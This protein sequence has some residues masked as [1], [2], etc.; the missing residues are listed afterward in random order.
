MAI[1]STN[2]VIHRF[3]QEISAY[4]PGGEFYSQI[5]PLD[6]QAYAIYSNREENRFFYVIGDGEHT[7]TEIRDGKGNGEAYKEYPVLTK[8][9]LNVIVNGVE[10]EVKERKA[11]DE[12]LQAQIDDKENIRKQIDEYLQ[13]QIDENDESISEL[14]R[15]LTKEI[16]ER[17]HFDELLDEALSEEIQNREDAIA[18][19]FNQLKE[20]I[21]SHINDKQNP[22]KVTKAQVGLSNVDNTSDLSKPISIATQTALDLKIDK[23]TETN[24]VYGTDSL[25]NQTTYDIESFSKVDDVKINGTSVVTDKVASFSLGTMA[26][27]NV[28]NYYTKEMSDTLYAGIDYETTIDNHISDTSNPHN[29]TKEQIGLGNVDNTSD[30]DKPISK[31]TQQELD[32]LTDNLSIEVNRATAKED[33]INS[34]LLNEVTRAKAVEKTL[35][36]NLEEEITRATTKENELKSAIESE[37]L[38]AT[39]AEGSLSDT[40]LDKISDIN[41]LYGTNST[42]DQTSYDVDSFGKVDDVK[43]G[44]TSV[45]ENKIATLGTMAGENVIDYSTKAV[46]DTLYAEKSIEAVLSTEIS[47]R[48]TADVN[49]QNAIDAEKD[50]ALSQEGL[51]NDK[52]INE[53]Q[54]RENADTNLQSQIDAITASSDVTDVVG[55]YAQLQSYNI[56]SLAPNSIIKVLKD[57]SRDDGT[58]YYRWVIEN[59]VGSWSLIG[60]EGPYYTKSEANTT[61]VPQTRTINGK[62]LSAN[63]TLNAGD[64]GADSSGSAMIA[65]Q[66]AKTYADSLAN[67]YAT[68]AQGQLADTA[69]QPEDLSTVATTGDYNDLTNKP[70]IPVAQVNVD[71]NSTSG[72]TQI[73]NKPNLSQVAISGDYNDLSNLP[74]IPAAQIQSDWNQTDET[75]L[76]YIKNKPYIPSGVTVDQTYDSTSTNAQS[77]IA[78]SQAISTRQEKLT[79][80]T[81]INI[82]NGVISSTQTSVEWGNVTGT[83]NDQTDLK[84]V[85]DTKVDEST[86]ATVATSGDYNDLVNKPV[87]ISEFTNDANYVT[88]SQFETKQDILVSGTN[89]KTVNNQSLL[90]S[91]NIEIESGSSTAEEIINANKAT[92]ATNPLS[93][94]QGTEQEYN[95]YEMTSWKNWKTDTVINTSEGIVPFYINSHQSYTKTYNNKQYFI[96]MNTS[97]QWA[98][99]SS[100]DGKNFISVKVF[101]DGEDIDNSAQFTYD[102]TN[103]IYYIYKAGSSFIYTSSNLVDWISHSVTTPSSGSYT[104]FECINGMLIMFIHNMSVWYQHYL[105]KSTDG[106]V[107]WVETLDNSIPNA[108]YYMTKVN[109]FLVILGGSYSES[110]KGTCYYSSDGNTWRGSRFNGTTSPGST[111]QCICYANGKYILGG[112][113]IWESTDLETWTYV[114]S[115]S[116]YGT[117]ESLKN[118][119]VYNGKF[120]FIIFDRGSTYAYSSDGINWTT[121]DTGTTN[122]IENLFYGSDGFVYYTYIQ[123]SQGGLRSN[124]CDFMEKQCY[125]LDSELTT[126]TVI[127]SEPS[128]ASQLT[129]TSVGVGSITLSDGHTYNRNSSSDIETYRSVGEVHPDYICN[130]NNVGVKIG[131]TLIANNTILDTVPTQGSTNAITSGAV[132]EVLGDLETILHNLN[133]GS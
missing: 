39:Q 31:A 104:G 95:Q 63:V 127:Y 9:N 68:A 60:E 133:S 52:I 90:G 53:I 21:D 102:D 94:W 125:T 78:V 41:K 33:S 36:D 26:Q 132:Y 62:A 8:N 123:G 117:L 115:L 32:T 130:I 51:L 49:L 66:N 18:N 54:D 99:F 42:G 34:A 119:L 111:N 107:T 58:T 6:T 10:E 56:S 86:L 3:I 82:T 92:G 97:R 61:F 65:E 77:G 85:L 22:H 12:L 108:G 105:A 122:G 40:K 89:I 106:G 118:R 103:D 83:L 131:N 100:E 47:N 38:R 20:D 24:R 114:T 1:N 35:M 55:T 17:K 5:I 91:G 11:A 43:I 113:T 70:S 101:N 14:Q 15:N 44:N 110:Y 116:G 126:S 37:V 45:V 96:G 46:A 80:G 25:G 76:D 59:E 112:A 75:A 19:L 23:I 88:E 71:W 29:I 7:Y 79:A 16:D 4:E 129:V 121:V 30:V 120:Y 48:E 84:N 73:L 67:N 27:Q 13:Q 57:E 87:N 2:R 28:E 109:G 74:E 98:L 81:G 93:I 128:V 50:R 64:V 124:I 72:I 69:V